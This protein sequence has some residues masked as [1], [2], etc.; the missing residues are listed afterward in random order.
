MKKSE[1]YT[2]KEPV[3]ISLTTTDGEEFDCE[4]LTRFPLNGKQYIILLPV[5]DRDN[6]EASALA[7][8]YSEDENGEPV[9]DLIEDDDEYEAVA[10]RYDE[11]M[12]EAEYDELVDAGKIEE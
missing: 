7:Y 2:E 3:I 5:E 1:V 4:V 6:V 12:D 11:I 9:L 8:I 10:D